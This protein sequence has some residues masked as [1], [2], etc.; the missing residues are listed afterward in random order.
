MD[1]H[2]S[3]PPSPTALC[4]AGTHPTTSATAVHATVGSVWR[5][6]ERTAARHLDDDAPK[7]AA[8]AAGVTGG[9]GF[10]SK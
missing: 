4:S 3:A 2:L 9:D 7:A 8:S 6:I 10:D 1:A 5:Y